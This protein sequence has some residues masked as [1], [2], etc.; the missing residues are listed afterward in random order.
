[1]EIGNEGKVVA[2]VV[3]EKVE[4]VLAV[5]KRSSVGKEAIVIGEAASEFDVVAM[6]TVVGGRRIIPPPA[7]DPVP[8]IC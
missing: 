2:A 8:R 3:P 4:D 1:M 6:E 5:M 7:G